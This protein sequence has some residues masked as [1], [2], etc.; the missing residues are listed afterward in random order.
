MG[1]AGTPYPSPVYSLRNVTAQ[2]NGSTI[3]IASCTNSAAPPVIIVEISATATVQLQG[4]HDGSSWSNAGAALTSSAV[5]DL[6]VGVRFW[7]ANVTSYG[8]GTVTASVGAVP[9]ALGR[10]VVPNLYQTTNVP[11]QGA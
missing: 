7:R 8:S 1:I 3:D 4:S 11:S 9:D 5:K 6:I 2:V 10:I